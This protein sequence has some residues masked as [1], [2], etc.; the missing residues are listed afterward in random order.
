MSVVVEPHWRARDPLTWLLAL[1]NAACLAF[2]TVDW[3][4]SAPTPRP[5]LLA[6]LGICL[7]PFLVAAGVALIAIVLWGREWR[8]TALELGVALMVAVGF[9]V[10]AAKDG[11]FAVVIFCSASAGALGVGLVLA[12]APWLLWCMLAVAC[13]L[14]SAN[15][16]LASLGGA[17]FVGAVCTL[18]VIELQAR[19]ALTRLVW[20]RDPSQEGRQWVYVRSRTS[21]AAALVAAAVVLAT[22]LGVALGIAVYDDARA[23]ARGSRDE[24]TRAVQPPSAVVQQWMESIS[25]GSQTPQLTGDVLARAILSDGRSGERILD[26]RVVY[27]TVTTLDDFGSDRLQRTKS[28]APSVLRDALD[29]EDDGWIELARPNAR[30]PLVI[31]SITQYAPRK[32]TATDLPLLRLQPLLAVKAEELAQLDDGTLLASAAKGRLEYAVAAD[33]RTPQLNANFPGAA[34]HFDPRY[35]A[36]PTADPALERIVRVAEEWS[37]QAESDAECALAIVERFQNDFTYSLEGTGADGLE[38]LARCLERRAGSCTPI[39]ATCVVMLRSQGIPSRAV[40][41]LLGKEFDSETGAYILRQRHGHAWVEAHFEGLGW[42]RLEPTPSSDSRTSGA[43][44]VDPLDD[45]GAELAQQVQSLAA[46][47]VSVAKLRELGAQLAR[48]PSA[49]AQAVGEG[50]TAA[51]AVVGLV[52]LIV[53]AWLL[54]PARRALESAREAST[55][56][57]RARAYEERLVDALVKLGAQAG[58]A[59]TLREIATSPTLRIEEELQPAL[60]RAV[61][62]LNAVRFG[63]ATLEREEQHELDELLRELKAA[64]SEPSEPEVA[65]AT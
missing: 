24:R 56:L 54:R 39:A 20:R 15:P 1:A 31:A 63:G 6:F 52:G 5:S 10:S 30:A 19:A 43:A 55:P 36:L 32:S 40:A 12:P 65:P 2:T 57:G 25:L 48:A 9:A 3:I 50:R 21:L 11:P 61:D 49:L 22:W 29:G 47:D 51:L 18:G 64:R 16:T 62:V 37:D 17:L 14:Y 45:V 13:S 33:P 27:F 38:G 26:G 34:Q 35:L 28:A 60:A 4:L 23:S 53:L 44:G 7:G 41:G 59:R 8:A 42:V 58:R 46:G